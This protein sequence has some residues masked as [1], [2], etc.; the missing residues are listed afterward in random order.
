MHS[1]GIRLLKL[2]RLLSPY[3]GGRWLFAQIFSSMVPYSGSVGPRIRV[4]EP[5]RAEV[6]IPD[7]RANRNHLS[8]VH[9]IALMNV[10]EQASGLAMLVGLP[11]GI[12]AIV[13]QISMQYLKKARGTIRAVS[14]VVVPAVTTDTEIDVTA[15]C[16]DHEGIVVARATV[17]WRVGPV[18]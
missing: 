7:R 3:P 15:E 18:R 13:T 10:A 16:L 8:S 12:R 17:R 4:L 11:D 6:E 1:P 5:G 14:N 9:A 2:W